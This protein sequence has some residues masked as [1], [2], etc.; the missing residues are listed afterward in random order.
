M[1]EDLGMPAAL[2]SHFY[3]FSSLPGRGVVCPARKFWNNYSGVALIG[4]AVLLLGI[5][6]I[7]RV[8]ARC[9]NGLI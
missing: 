8:R 6:L 5:D 4:F 1:V 3:N 7:L 9:D 2:A